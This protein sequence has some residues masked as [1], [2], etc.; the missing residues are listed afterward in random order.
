[1]PTY[2]FPFQRAPFS[3]LGQDCFQDVN[4]KR[5]SWDL[6]KL[7]L[8]MAKYLEDRMIGGFSH[9]ILRHTPSRGCVKYVFDPPSFDRGLS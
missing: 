1:M 9:M 5:L 3:K 7:A 6:R 2:E 8:S 4:H